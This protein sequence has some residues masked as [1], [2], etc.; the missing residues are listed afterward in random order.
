[1]TA[2][3]ILSIT[4]AVVIVA[5]TGVAAYRLLGTARAMAREV[6]RSVERLG[7]LTQELQDELAVTQTESEHLQRRV[8]RMTGRRTD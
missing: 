7:P 3:T 8:E 6:G 5:V 2:F 1:M 4:L